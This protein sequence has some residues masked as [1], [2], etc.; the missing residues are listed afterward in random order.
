MKIA[1]GAYSNGQMYDIYIYIYRER[2]RDEEESHY[3]SVT[4]G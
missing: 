2:E 1:K 4:I 3:T